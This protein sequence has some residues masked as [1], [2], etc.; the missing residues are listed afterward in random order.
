MKSDQEFM[1]SV[2]ETVA[3]RQQ[4]V[5]AGERLRFSPAL[6]DHKGVKAAIAGMCGLALWLMPLASAGEG[7]HIVFSNMM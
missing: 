2:W 1:Q 5:L 3:Q 6:A 7:L 4:L